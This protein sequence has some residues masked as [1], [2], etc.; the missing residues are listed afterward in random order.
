MP[1]SPH[2]VSRIGV[3]CNADYARIYVF[4]IIDFSH[5]YSSCGCD[6]KGVFGIITHMID[7]GAKTRI[8][9]NVDLGQKAARDLLGGVLRYAALHPSW[10][11]R[12]H[13]GHPM[14]NVPMSSANWRPDGI[15]T[16]R[17]LGKALVKRMRQLGLKGIISL[18]DDEASCPHVQGVGLRHVG[19]DNAR[20]GEAGA[21]FLMA[22]KL[23][24]FAYVPA[25]VKDASLDCRQNAFAD[26]LAAAGFTPCIYRAPRTRQNSS[27]DLVRWIADLPKPCGVMAA[28]DQRAKNVLDACRIAQID[29]PTQILVLGVDNEEFICENTLPSLSSVLLDFAGGGLRAAEILQGMIDGGGRDCAQ[30]ATPLLYGV[31]QIVERA[32]TAD[33]SGTARS[34]A[35]ACEF[36][37]RNAACPIGIDDIATAAG[38]S[39][40]LLEK[41]FRAVMNTTAAHELQHIRLELVKKQLAETDLPLERVGERC[42]IN[43]AAHLKRLFKRRFGCTMREWRAQNRTL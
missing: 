41:H 14:N 12:I 17:A 24:H 8:L 11:V 30:S 33:V 16:D 43:A 2:I 1:L 40:R 42:G 5:I 35:L 13:H 23:R 31:R 18:N 4:T 19:C 25:N 32:S 9:V 15:I 37:R 38:T 26:T 28:F 3:F 10:D 39:R 36:M 34:V 21:R 20:V 7:S 22:K 29:V 27:D 6:C